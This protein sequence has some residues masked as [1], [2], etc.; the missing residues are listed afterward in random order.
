MFKVAKGL[1]EYIRPNY[2]DEDY[3]KKE[4]KEE[5]EDVKLGTEL[6]MVR[7]YHLC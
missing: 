3:E 1:D 4:E 7:N 6:M 5:V 2:I